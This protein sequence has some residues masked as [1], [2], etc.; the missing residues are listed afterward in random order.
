KQAPVHAA[1]FGMGAQRRHARDDNDAQRR[2]HSHLHGV[3][4]LETDGV[5]EEQQ[6]RHEYHAA[7]DAQKPR[8]KP[9]QRAD[10][11]QRQNQLR[12]NGQGLWRHGRVLSFFGKHTPIAVRWKGPISPHAMRI[13][14]PISR[15]LALCVSAPDEMISTPAAAMA[16][17]V[18]NVTAPEA[19]SRER[20]AVM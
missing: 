12:S 20:P 4:L 10:R 3:I 17:I 6:A 1:S 9:A 14:S 7:T 11:Q 16:G 13:S 15:F 8:Q 18:S 2:R 5:E 19:S